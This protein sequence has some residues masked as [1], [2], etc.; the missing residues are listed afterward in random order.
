MSYQYEY[1]KYT[2]TDFLMLSEAM[3]PFGKKYGEDIVQEALEKCWKGEGTDFPL[4]YLW[5]AA[6]QASTNAYRHQQVVQEYARRGKAGL[7]TTGSH[8][9]REKF[10]RLKYLVSLTDASDLAQRTQ[11]HEAIRGIEQDIPH[12]LALFKHLK[13]LEVGVSEATLSRTRGS[14]SNGAK[15]NDP[16]LWRPGH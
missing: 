2:A 15:N 12:G 8:G 16:L 3:T 10:C 13:A 7:L 14:R 6:E 4:H 5:E 1:A 9:R 11:I